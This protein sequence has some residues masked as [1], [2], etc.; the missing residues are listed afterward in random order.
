MERAERVVEHSPALTTKH[1]LEEEHVMAATE[2]ITNRDAFGNWLSGFTDGEG[3]FFLGLHGNLPHASFLIAVRSD[4]H[5]VMS[6]IHEFWGGIGML[7]LRRPSRKAPGQ[8]I[9]LLRVASVADLR[10][11]VIPHFHAYPLRAKKRRDFL[12]W[13]QGV[14]WIARMRK[15]FT[16]GYGRKRFTDERISEFLD[17]RDAL[18]SQR[19]FESDIVPIPRRSTDF[20]QHALFA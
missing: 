1:S 9:S 13:E 12:V 17:I 19:K 6:Q 5:A 2:S 10:R 11:V 16:S 3:C 4:D 18:R 20:V 7:K 8:P 14:D 15:A